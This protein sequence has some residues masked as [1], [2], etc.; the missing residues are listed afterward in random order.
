[1]PMAQRLASQR[2]QVEHPEKA[3]VSQRIA[4]DLS[5]RIDVLLDLGLGYLSLERSTPTLVARRTATLAPG[6]AGALESVWRRL[7]PRR[8]I[9][10]AASGRHRSAARALDRLKA[11][12]NSLFVVEHEL[13]VIRHADWIVDVGPAAGRTRRRDPLQRSACRACKKSKSSQTRRV[14]FRRA[15]RCPIERHVRRK[16]WLRLQG[17]TRNNLHDLDVAFPLGVFTTV[18]GV[19]GSGKSS[20]VS[21]VLV[22]LVAEQ[23]GHRDARRRRRGRRARAN[24][25]S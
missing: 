5:A 4:Q 20:L 25:R 7:R 1:M 13:D 22:E 17:V 11:S 16:G 14:S 10:R 24:R 12:G 3:I 21:Q 23:L 8:T 9:R 2:L 18:T 15:S 19:S 6:D